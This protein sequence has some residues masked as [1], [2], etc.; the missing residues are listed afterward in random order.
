M[1]IVSRRRLATAVAAAVALLVGTEARGSAPRVDMAHARVAGK[2]VTAPS[3]R[4]T[5]VLTLDPALQNDLAAL[6]AR[7]RAREAGAV[8]VDVRTGRVLAWASAGGDGRDMV[9]H[10]HAPPASVFKV[11]TAAALIER[12]GVPTW[13]RQCYVGGER[14][15]R[16]G[17]LRESGAGEGV[18]CERL[19]TALGYSR[20][21]VVAGLALR[22]LRAGA[23][24]SVASALGLEGQVPIDVEVEP[25]RVQ[26][27]DDA[28]GLVR[29][30]A[31]FGTGRASV[32][33]AAYMM[34]VIA[35]GG[36]R[37]GLSLVDHLDSAG[38]AQP[39]PRAEA[40]WALRGSTAAAL[41]RML[42]VTVREGTCARAFRGSRGDRY[43]GRMRVAAK[44][45]TLAS[46]SPARMYSWFAGF[47]PADRPA[48]AVA[49]MLANDL[50]WWQ[51]ANQVGRDV[52]RAYFA[53]RGVSGV[54]HPLR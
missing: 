2:V 27:P 42:E 33:A 3:D 32:L 13:A 40:A 30:A 22:H 43:L 23:L 47:A 50:S 6:L 48:I 16:V 41:T 49:V 25:S 7:A 26:V 39:P 20:N 53:E 24:L 46:G 37:L 18:R 44:T 51:K 29:A 5:V 10:A 17:D 9:G 11:V 12:A 54:S 35:R 1:P 45:G 52:M 4:G 19:S 34:S 21:L 8:V 28:P 38:A 14:S 15:A 31:G 36:E